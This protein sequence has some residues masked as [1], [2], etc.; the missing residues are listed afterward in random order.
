MFDT[1]QCIIEYPPEEL[2]FE[3]WSRLVNLLARIYNAASGLIVQLRHDEFN[4]VSTSDNSDNFLH[5]HSTWP[6]EMRS[7]CRYMIENKERRLYVNSAA[8]NDKWKCATPVSEGPVRSYLG[9]PIYWPDGSVFGSFCVIDTK[10]TD[11]PDNLIEM[12]GHLKLIVESELRHVWDS[13]KIKSLLSEKLSVESIAQQEQAELELIKRTLG[14]QESINTATLASLKDVVIRVDGQK[15]ILSCNQAIQTLFGYS[16]DELT[17][18]N[19]HR[20]IEEE[21]TALANQTSELTNTDM[22]GRH[23]DGASFHIHVSITEIQV[24]GH[25]QYIYLISD[26]TEKVQNQEILKQLALYDSLTNCANRNLLEERFEYELSK[27]VRNDGIFSLAFI[28]LNDFKPI[29]DK[30]GHAAG[31]FALKHAAERLQ[32]AVRAYDL[33]ARVGGDE[34]VVLFNTRVRDTNIKEKLSASLQQPLFYHDHPIQLSASIGV[35]LYPEHGATLPCLLAHADKEMYKEKLAI[36]KQKL[37][38]Q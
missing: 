29:N 6:W 4:V 14:L 23:K 27:A 30:F 33:V 36:K 3:K 25:T 31:D 24:S 11:Y 34:F 10:P 20:I 12:L 19:I 21:H 16:I 37:N 9:Y 26:I 13:Q 35:A 15:N 2:D 22:L 1:S 28:D 8:T 7:F 32:K 38:N 18:V 5:V 17:G